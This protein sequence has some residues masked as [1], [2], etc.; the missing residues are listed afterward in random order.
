MVPPQDIDAT[1][2]GQDS[3]ASR[4]AACEA[5]RKR[6]SDWFAGATASALNAIYILEPV[7]DG[8]G[9]V[10]DFRFVFANALGAT[11][12]QRDEQD[13]GE[14]LLSEALPPSRREVVPAQCRQ[15]MASRRP[16]VEEFEVPEFPEHGRWLRHQVA[17]IADGVVITSENIS[18][19]K[20]AE[21]DLQQREQWFRAAADGNLNA[22]F[23]EEAVYDDAGEV[24]DFRF[25]HVN[26]QGGRLVSMDP[27][28]MVGQSICELFPVNRTHGYFE[29]YREV[30][31]QKRTVVDEFAINVPGI[32]ARWLRQLAMPWA[33][34]VVLSAEDISEEVERKRELE[35][36]HQSLVAFLENM[37]GP[38]WIADDAGHLLFF[39]EAL[40]RLAPPGAITRDG[41]TLL[42]TVF[43]PVLGALCRANNA[44]VLAT[45]MPIHTLEQ[46][47]LEDGRTGTYDVHKFP[48]G[49]GP[50]ALVGGFAIDVTEREALQRQANLFG[51]I[52]RAAHDAIFAVDGAARI[53]EWSPSAER[54]YGWTTGEV[55]GRD[56][57]LLM[58]ALAPQDCHRMLADAMAGRPVVRQPANCRCANGR[59]ISVELSMAA[60]KTAEDREPWVAVLVSDVSA[61]VEAEARLDFLASHDAATGRLNREGLEA[62]LRERGQQVPG[63]RLLARI[64]LREAEPLRE[65]LGASVVDALLAGFA[66]RIEQTLAAA[67]PLLAR[68][69]PDQLLLALEAGTASEAS[70]LST[71]PALIGGIELDGQRYSLGPRMGYVVGAAGDEPSALLRAADIA[72]GAAVTRATVMPIA[73]A[74]RMAEQLARRVQIQRELAQAIQA[75]ELSLVF[76]PVFAQA[77]EGAHGV[78]GLEAL[79]RWHSA[80]LGPV[81]PGEFIPVAE[82]SSLIVD[83]GD[84]ILARA[85]AELQRLAAA[86][87]P[88]LY[89]AV[90]VAEAQL[91]RPDFADR[92]ADLLRQSGLDPSQLELEITER[93]LMADTATHQ[94]NLLA[95]RGHGVRLSVDDFGTG[96]SSLAY[97]MRFAVDKIKIDRSFV[98]GLD[99]GEGNPAVVRAMVALAEALGLACVSEGV[100][101]EGQLAALQSLGCRQFQGFLL[102]RPM[103]AGQLHGWLA[104][105]IAG[106]R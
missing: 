11:L 75:D 89:I 20:Q 97:L 105:R 68:D 76:Q 30:F 31:L 36:R 83:L 42:E 13:L 38:A 2:A 1:L 15:V 10:V 103:P 33:R 71:W 14:L 34:G 27:A 40:A 17:P 59:G 94:R 78:V 101:T 84:W 77:G 45:G 66:G 3:P 22:L 6:L 57:S 21:A 99:S 8:A 18:A 73:Y 41:S 85:C 43:G 98:T 95:L 79:V 63:S 91:A 50:D 82:E 69:G 52:G 25:V 39:N 56:S 51:A 48:L 81:G 86:G 61:R 12:L 4:L 64:S 70:L 44:Q 90:N 9:S 19:R 54:L 32:R 104:G 5:E 37:P 74:P 62:A 65:L 58:P 23:I 100:E 24:V 55:I 88:G 92:V 67:S 29:R 35:R 28:D 93:T 60:F 87:L 49:H 80:T 102:A 47:P 96:Y 53:V 16:L 106:P 7:R 46:G 26:E 72:H